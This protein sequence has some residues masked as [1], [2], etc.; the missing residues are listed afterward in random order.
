[1]TVMVPTSGG[2]YRILAVNICKTCETVL[3][4]E[5]GLYKYYSR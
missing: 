3:N 1:M 4:T 5:Q 2:G